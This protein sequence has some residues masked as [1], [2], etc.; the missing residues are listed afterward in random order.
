MDFRCGRI[1]IPEPDNCSGADNLSLNT[2]FIV[3]PDDSSAFKVS[4]EL[5]LIGTISLLGVLGNCLSALVLRRDRERRESLLLLQVLALAD[6]VYLVAALFKYPLKYLINE[7]AYQH[8]QLGAFPL[9]K[10][11][12]T[13]CIWT[14]VLVTIDRYVYVCHPL[15]AQR[16]FTRRSRRLWALGI[17]VAGVLYNL[18]RFFDSCISTFILPC[19]RKHIAA[20]VYRTAFANTVYYILYRH[21]LYIL[22]LYAVPL[23][24][25]ACL[26]CRLVRA[27][28]RS[29]KQ[30]AHCVHTAYPHDPTTHDNNATT[31]LVTIVVI[32]LICESLEPVIHLLSFMESQL[33][34]RVMSFNY[35][36]IYTVSALL[37]VVNSSVNF[38]IYVVLGQ[39]F[40]RILKETF[41]Q[42]FLTTTSF[43]TRE[44]V[45]LQ[46]QQPLQQHKQHTQDKHGRCL[47]DQLM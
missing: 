14:M 3:A 6:G 12:Q 24:I 18:P 13:I 45:P 34:V 15:R 42:S 7:Y 31:F 43:L 46:Q 38:V 26:N 4:V 20:M 16:L 33:G 29:R 25:L 17:F 41:K 21:A 44:T 10:T 27:I 36:N 39:R 11:S 30:H 28:R 22:L 32:F 35:M 9:L 47:E 19:G 8:I 40:R 2:G 37:M 5:Y 23:T 1:S